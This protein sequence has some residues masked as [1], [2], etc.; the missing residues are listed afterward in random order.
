LIPIIQDNQRLIDARVSLDFS[1]E[2]IYSKQHKIDKLENKKA[3][4][5][6]EIEKL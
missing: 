2:H 4:L 1:K 3:D 6:N 5:E